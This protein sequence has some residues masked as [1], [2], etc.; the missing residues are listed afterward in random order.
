MRLIWAPILLLMVCLASA[1]PDMKVLP[2]GTHPVSIDTIS[3]VYVINMEHNTE[4]LRLFQETFTPTG[5]VFERF[6]AVVGD[7]SLIQNYKQAQLYVHDESI[8]KTELTNGEFGNFLSHAAIF[9]Q[10]ALSNS[11]ITLVFEDRAR[12]SKN[13][14][15]ELQSVLT[16][17]PDDWD[18]IY[19]GCN[20]TVRAFR[21]YPSRLFQTKDGRFA[22]LD[23]QCVAGNYAYLVS[24]TGAQKLTRNLFPI[25]GPTDEHLRSY[26]FSNHY[27]PFNAYCSIPELA[28]P[29][30]T[31]PSEIDKMGRLKA[32][33]KHS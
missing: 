6:A 15:A 30:N 2:N 29:D 26:F 18:L 20:T 19:L 24:A 9:E 22:K 3:H 8:R 31:V 17:A 21:C 7:Q 14:K 33:G 16:H 13:F 28:H 27:G 11:S 5:L 1:C 12:V 4:R 32:Q 25:H 10:A 23:E